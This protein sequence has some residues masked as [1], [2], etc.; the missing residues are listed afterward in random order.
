MNIKINQNCAETWNF[1]VNID[2]NWGQKP[3]PAFVV[4]LQG[5]LKIV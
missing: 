5:D 1:T 2:K 3:M 4:S